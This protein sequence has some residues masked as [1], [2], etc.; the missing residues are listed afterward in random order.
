MRTGVRLPAVGRKPRPTKAVLARSGQVLVDGLEIP[1]T[2]MGRGIGLMFRRRLE[3]GRGMLI[4]PCNGI[5]MFFMNFPIDAVFLDKKLR[6]LKVYPS[7][8]IWRVVPLVWGARCVLEL[9]AGTVSGLGLE[10]GEQIELR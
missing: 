4:D 7:L 1:R 3:A 9:P 2:F 5:H 8:G 6:V 10:K